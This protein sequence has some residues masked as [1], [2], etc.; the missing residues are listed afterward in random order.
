MLL[1]DGPEGLLKSTFF[2]IMGYDVYFTDNL[3]IGADGKTVIEQTNGK[4]IVELSELA[5][6]N[7]KENEETKAFITRRQDEAR[8]PYGRERSD[9]PRQFILGATSNK[10]RP[11]KDTDGNRRWWIVVCRKRMEGEALKA[12]RDQ[13]WAEAAAREAAGEPKLAFA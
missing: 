7:K 8:R 6:L 3:P 4:W 2:R 13:I 10:L 1:L 12:E 11:F 9:Y 5:A